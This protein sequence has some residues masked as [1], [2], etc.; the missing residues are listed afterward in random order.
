M[1]QLITNNNYSQHLLKAYFMPGTELAE[2]TAIHVIT[3]N[4]ITTL[5][6]KYQNYSHFTDEV[7]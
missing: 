1:C 5:W 4:L 7:S 2:G 3:F 6:G